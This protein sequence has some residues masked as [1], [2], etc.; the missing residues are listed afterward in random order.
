METF[1]LSVVPTVK[2]SRPLAGE[3]D[4]TLPKLRRTS[5]EAGG[6]VIKYEKMFFPGN[7]FL[8]P[9]T[10]RTIAKRFEAA[11]RRRLDAQGR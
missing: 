2:T 4:Q 3:D 1:C 11:R 10:S 8:S 5:R 9:K 6:K 7:F